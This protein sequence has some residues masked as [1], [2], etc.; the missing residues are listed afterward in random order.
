MG[1]RV[2]AFR[3]FRLIYVNARALARPQVGNFHYI[4]RRRKAQYMF[5]PKKQ[6]S[7][8][9]GKD[10]ADFSCASHYWLDKQAFCGI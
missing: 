3:Q 5:C 7:P 4:T 2:F 10:F 9:L 1:K 6:E 8:Q